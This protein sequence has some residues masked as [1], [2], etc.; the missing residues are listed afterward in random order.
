MFIKKKT[1]G[2]ATLKFKTIEQVC[3]LAPRLANTI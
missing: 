2:M 1:K 3:D